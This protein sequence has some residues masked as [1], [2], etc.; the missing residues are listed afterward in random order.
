MMTEM[1][2][3]P[4]HLTEKLSKIVSEQGISRSELARRC[5][6][7][8]TTVSRYFEGA[9][10]RPHTLLLMADALGVDPVWLADEAQPYR[11][12]YPRHRAAGMDTLSMAE[13]LR[14]RFDQKMASAKRAIDEAEGIDWEWLASSIEGITLW[15]AT[16][17]I[18]KKVMAGLR[19]ALGLFRLG[20]SISPFTDRLEMGS[21][22]TIEKDGS[23]A[24]VGQY[25]ELVLRIRTLLDRF[26][27]PHVRDDEGKAADFF[28]WLVREDGAWPAEDTPELLEEAV[29]AYRAA[30]GKFK[31]K[32]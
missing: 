7:A 4:D 25:L 24:V 19:V 15:D 21:S 12:D 28:M 27:P 31:P 8:T 29:A 2:K 6:V 26:M 10:P 11:A 22:F 1:A 9:A 5:G 18:P 30:G 32:K 17:S 3:S 23:V 14:K 20:S 16:D 13:E